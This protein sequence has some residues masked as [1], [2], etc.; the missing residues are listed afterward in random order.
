MTT[1]EHLPCN[2]FVE[3]VTEYLDGAMDGPTRARFEHHI[4]LCPGCEDYLEQI[5]M[6]RRATGQVEE[7]HLSEPARSRLLE[8]FRDWNDAAQA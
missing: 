1:P 6:T 4:E 7:R 3:L 5:E 2:E 8:A